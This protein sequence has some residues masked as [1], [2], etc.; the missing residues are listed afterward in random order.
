M[1]PDTGLRD[2]HGL[3]PVDHLFSSPEKPVAKPLKQTN[4]NRKN[5]NATISSEED[6]DVAES[7]LLLGGRIYR[8]QRD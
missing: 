5:P 4:G 3:E 7:T 2:E 1:L 6:M 8:G